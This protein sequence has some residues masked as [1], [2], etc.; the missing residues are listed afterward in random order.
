MRLLSVVI[1]LLALSQNSFAQSRPAENVKS[2]T[3]VISVGANVQVSKSRPD[4]L[5]MEVLIASDPADPRH[6]LACSMFVLK[7]PSPYPYP[8]GVVVY[9]SFDGGATWQETLHI[10]EGEVTGDPACTFGPGGVAYVAALSYEGGPKKGSGVFFFRSADSGKTWEKPLHMLQIINDREFVTVDNTRG[11]YRGRVYLIGTGFVEPLGAGDFIG[12]F[13]L[14][15]S[16]DSGATFLGPIILGSTEPG[17]TPNWSGEGVVLSDG[18]FVDIIAEMDHEKETM[19]QT[20]P[21]KANGRILA[22]SSEDGGE[23]FI[24]PVRVSDIYLNLEHIGTSMS[25]MRLAVDSSTGPFKDRVYAVW[26]DLRFGRNQILLSYSADRGKSW[27]TPA[28]VSD[29]LPRTDFEDAPD[30]CV[31]TVAVNASGVVG[32]MWYDR[33]DSPDNLGY[34]P[35]FTVSFDGG[36]TFQPSVKI[37]EAPESLQNSNLIRLSAFNSGGGAHFVPGGPLGLSVQLN[38]HQYHGGDTSGLTATPDGAFHAVW[39][40][41]RT[42]IPQLWTAPISVPGRAV[43]NGSEELAALSDVTANVALALG[44]AVYDRSKHVLTVDAYVENTSKSALSGPMMMRVQSVRSKLGAVKIANADNHVE[45]AGAVWDFT[46]ELENGSL[47]A[48]ARSRSKRLKFQVAEFP[49]AIGS[50]EGLSH[51]LEIQSKVLAKSEATDAAPD[52]N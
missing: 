34:W 19:Q 15:R 4:Q 39:V 3:T 38:P 43:P 30:S 13:D 27:S 9:A 6:L 45:A 11:K 17:H 37:S 50:Y 46:G 14:L 47:P 35:R 51:I 12:G 49:G 29:D 20:R 7:P 33:R 25:L 28:V 21:Y 22:V 36:E 10:A 18:T 26:G 41:N 48:G 44:S 23:S 16:L 42:Q 1:L 40:D 31:A 24:K 2:A 32:V 52:Q 5:H 8:F